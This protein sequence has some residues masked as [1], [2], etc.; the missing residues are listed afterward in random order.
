MGNEWLPSGASVRV[1]GWGNTRYPGSSYPN[2][3]HCVNVNIISNQDCN[4]RNS[5]NGA[6]LA[7]MYCAGVNG[8]G[9]DACQGD[10]GGPTTYNNQVIGATSWGIGC[11]EANYPGV[12]TDVAMFRT[13]VDQQ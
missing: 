3:L 4:A 8:G 1:C 2:E 9:K 10:S 12:Y 7:G 5:Y 13:W 6:V 11:A